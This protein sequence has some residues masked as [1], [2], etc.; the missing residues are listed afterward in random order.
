MATFITGSQE[1]SL[2][3]LLPGRD[4]AGE[5]NVTGTARDPEGWAYPSFNVAVTGGENRAPVVDPPLRDTTLVAGGRTADIL[6]MEH[7][8]DPD[9]DNLTY[10]VTSSTLTV[11]TADT[12]GHTLPVTTAAVGSATITVRRAEELRYRTAGR[13]P[14]SV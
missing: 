5:A 1:D 9:G 4:N 11:A 14:E 10:T 3:I 12:S 13:I 2:E 7:F 8:S 6:L